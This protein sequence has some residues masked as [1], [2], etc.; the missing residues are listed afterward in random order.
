MGTERSQIPNYQ[1]FWKFY[2]GEHSKPSTRRLHF[3][4]TTLVLALF[5]ASFVTTYRL[6]I[7]LPLAGYSFAW[8]GHF[9]F[10]KNRPAT[11]KY[12]FWSL[13]SDFVM[14]WYT[15]TGRMG[16]EVEKYGKKF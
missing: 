2:V 11:F 4:G 9:I 12:P 8:I 13:I 15:V 1:E 6:L 5:V 14:F 10:E 3:V 7:F 16:R